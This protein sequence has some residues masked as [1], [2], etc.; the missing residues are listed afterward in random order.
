[1]PRTRTGSKRTLKG[2]RLEARVTL[3]QK[4]LIL[5]AAELRGTTVTDFVVS[6]VQEVARNTIESFEVLRLRDE[7]RDAFVAA[8]LEPAM[9]NA[10]ARAAALRYKKS[11]DN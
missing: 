5:R 7:A 8:V 2:Q 6:S 1:M 4:R 3:E 10:A 9:P 11:L